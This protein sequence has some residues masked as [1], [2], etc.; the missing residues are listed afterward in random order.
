MP[1]QINGKKIEIIKA[2]RFYLSLRIQEK[3]A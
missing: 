2:V 1:T 3:L